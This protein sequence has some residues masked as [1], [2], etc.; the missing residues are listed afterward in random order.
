MFSL[1]HSYP[2]LDYEINGIIAMQVMAPIS[3]E[4]FST[5]VA[6]L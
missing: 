3:I 5:F 6:V 1:I 2:G 4:I